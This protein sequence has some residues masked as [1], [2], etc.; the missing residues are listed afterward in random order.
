MEPEQDEADCH[1]EVTEIT[2][3]GL[4]SLGVSLSSSRIRVKVI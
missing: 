3:S 4:R 1:F 2:T